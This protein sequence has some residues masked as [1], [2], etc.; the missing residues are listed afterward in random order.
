MEMDGSALHIDSDE[1]KIQMEETGEI[2]RLSFNKIS[3]VLT[4]SFKPTFARLPTAYTHRL[5]YW[6]RRR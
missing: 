2:G 4:F 3:E 6:S 1:A 5:I